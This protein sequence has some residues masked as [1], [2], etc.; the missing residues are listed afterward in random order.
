VEPDDSPAVA[1]RAE[2]VKPPFSE[3]LVVSVRSDLAELAGALL[4]DELGPFEEVEA[5]GGRTELVFFPSG[6][7]GSFAP[8]G[9][10][11][12]CA[13]SDADVASLLSASPEA[14]NA[15]HVWRMSV[16]R[17]W[18]ESW[19]DH[20]RPVVVGCVR[21]RPP[22][23][24]PLS[25]GPVGASLPM[26]DAVIDP[27]LAFGTGL[28]PTTRGVLGLMQRFEA[29]GPLLDAGTGT[30]ILTI[31]A[32]GLGF[33]P[34]MAF[35]NDPL[36]VQ[37]A[38]AN[39]ARNGVKARVVQAG[40]DDFPLEWAAD[41]TVVANIALQPALG[42]VARFA[43]VS[44]HTRSD[45]SPPLGSPLRRIVVSGIL[46]GAQEEEF[47]AAAAGHA[48]TC[49]ARASEGEW[50]TL[51]IEPVMAGVSEKGGSSCRGRSA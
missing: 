11:A 4:F 25:E 24:P 29:G 18:E 15:H 50:V 2:A 41:A 42:L 3:A 8:A 10:F 19:K 37:A 17:G 14:H 7:G 45:A 38:G 40:V 23:E 46:V 36:A 32:A 47:A 51:V 20:F 1:P 48:F 31:A 34:L 43:P 21:V 33:G 27:G 13:P 22:W 12:P 28:H 35:D 30:G 49:T 6:E 39:L 5:A 9:L 44:S 26:V 16:L